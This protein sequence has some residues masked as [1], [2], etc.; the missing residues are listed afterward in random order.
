MPY[1]QLVNVAKMSVVQMLAAKMLMANVPRTLGATALRYT[2]DTG[3]VL[4]VII[5]ANL[6]GTLYALRSFQC[7]FAATSHQA[8]DLPKTRIPGK[9]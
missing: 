7:T 8:N 4:L 3:A 5:I 9:E 1:K 6:L 2:P